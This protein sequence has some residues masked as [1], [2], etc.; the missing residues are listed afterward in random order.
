MARDAGERWVLA[1]DDSRFT[2]QLAV[3]SQRKSAERF[4]GGLSLGGPIHIYP[5][6]KN[7]STQFAVLY[8]SYANRAEADRE[9]HRRGHLK[10][11]V[12]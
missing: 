2:L 4:V 10:P 5:V 6:R 3:F 11:W 12:R 8:G 9:K 7:G 1:Q